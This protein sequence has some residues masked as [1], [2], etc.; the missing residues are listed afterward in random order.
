MFKTWNIVDD[1]LSD[2]IFGHYLWE[3]KL[4]VEELL[5]RETTVRIAGH[6]SIKPEQFPGAHVIPTFALHHD[7][8]VSRDE[9]WRHLENF[10]VHNLDYEKGLHRLDRNIF[11]DALTLFLDVSDQQ[12][13]GMSRWFSSF[14]ASKRPNVA[15]ILKGQYDWSARNR[16][17]DL[18]A[19]V[20]KD[21]PPVFKEHV[22]LCTRSEM[23]ADKYEQILGAKP[24]VLPSAL[25]PTEK[26]IRR[27]RERVGPRLGR[28]VVSF[29]AGARP[30][31][32]TAFIPDVVEQCGPLGVRFLIQASD[33]AHRTAGTESLKI[34]RGR[35]NVDFHEGDLSREQ[36]NDWIAQSVVLLPYDPERYQSRSSGV[37]QEAKG[38]GSPVIVPAGTWMAEEV[39]RLGN[40]LVFEEHNA[41]AI[42]Q[43]IARAQTDLMAL[44]ERAAACAAGHQRAHGA[45]RC[46]D[47]IEALFTRC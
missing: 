27:S 4:L 7:A 1:L 26:E 15:V 25:G 36:Y 28:L 13:L 43:C 29:V 34:L 2:D 37:Y 41:Q 32:G 24:L 12:L 30:E 23:S 14:E 11:S 8:S 31:R 44:R 46:V 39:S 21:C 10:V 40:G 17:L 38:F 5:H 20:W 18:Y 42:V 16:S 33:A 6:R 19:M 9:K 3:P 22:R 45:D 35:P 47:A